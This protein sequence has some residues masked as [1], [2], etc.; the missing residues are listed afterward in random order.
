ML[1]S[2]FNLISN[3]YMKRSFTYQIVPHKFTIKIDFCTHSD[4]FKVNNKM[5]V[6]LG[7]R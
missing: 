1:N 5:F 6:F 7:N 4:R 2:Q 3:I